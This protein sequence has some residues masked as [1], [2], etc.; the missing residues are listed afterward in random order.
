MTSKMREQTVHRGPVHEEATAIAE[1]ALRTRTTSVEDV[2]ARLEARVKAAL[3][4]AL[5]TP[6]EEVAEPYLWWNLWAAG[7]YKNF[8]PN[9]PLPPH[10]VIKAG[11]TAYVGT[12]L[13]LNPFPILPPPPGMSPCDVLSDFALRYEIRYEANILPTVVHNGSLV[14]GQCVYVDV[15]EMTPVDEGI[16]RMDVTARILGAVPPGIAP[17]FAGFARWTYDFDPEMF[18]PGP[19]PGWH[20]E[21]PIKFLIYS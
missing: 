8:S 16:C 12:V 9:G 5:T 15:L 17:H 20:Y 4:Q 6:H 21:F 7:P 1:R 11:E 10:Q 2:K 19:T 13:V 14:P 3:E 18:W